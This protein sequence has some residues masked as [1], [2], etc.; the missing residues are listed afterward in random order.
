VPADGEIVLSDSNAILATFAKKYLRTDWPPQDAAGMARVQR[1][2]AI[3]AGEIARE[4]ASARPVTVD[5][6]R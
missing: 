4:P 5:P 3:P 6:T 1:W 2:L